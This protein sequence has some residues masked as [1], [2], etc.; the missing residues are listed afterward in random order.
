MET[1]FSIS[2][3]NWE[4]YEEKGDAIVSKNQKNKFPGK[5]KRRGEGGDQNLEK[6]GGLKERAEEGA[7]KEKTKEDS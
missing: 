3:A 6:S 1:H 5:G 7:K 4:A 2:S